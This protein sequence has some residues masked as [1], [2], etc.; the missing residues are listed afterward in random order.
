MGPPINGTP[1]GGLG[2]KKFTKFSGNPCTT[3]LNKYNLKGSEC[4]S[5]RA[6]MA[7][8][9]LGGPNLDRQTT[10]RKKINHRYDWK[11]REFVY[12]PTWVFPKMEV[13]NNQ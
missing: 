10:G 3:N 9:F 2:P 12:W 7:S 4:F 8:A 11:T 13:Q 1:P 6:S 5:K